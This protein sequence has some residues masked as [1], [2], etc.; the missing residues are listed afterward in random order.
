MWFKNA[1]SNVWNATKNIVSDQRSPARK[2][3][4]EVV[5]SAEEIIPTNKLN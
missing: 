4:D 3:I 5:L 1:A 2:L